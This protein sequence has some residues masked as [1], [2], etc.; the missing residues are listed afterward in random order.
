MKIPTKN[1]MLQSV[2]DKR[3]EIPHDFWLVSI[4]TEFFDWNDV[5]FPENYKKVVLQFFAGR[6]TD[7]YESGTIEL[8]GRWQKDIEQNSKY[9]VD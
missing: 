9:I 7:F 3:V 5:W 1:G 2:L 4:A 6:E 8:P